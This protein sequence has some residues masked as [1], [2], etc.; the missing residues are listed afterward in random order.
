M[1]FKSLNEF[2]QLLEQKGELAKIDGA[3]GNLEMG[4]LT[5]L[6]W[7]AGGRALL[8]ENIK[9]YPNSYRVAT[10]LFATRKRCLLALD[11]PFDLTE[12]EA[13]KKF[14]E[15]L[16]GYKPIPP[17]RVA[18]GPIT[19]N[20]L[21]GDQVDLHKIPAPVWHELDGGKYI[22]TGCCVILKDPEG[23]WINVGTYRVMV[24]DS[25]TAGI[26]ISPQHQGTAI[27]KKYWQSGRSCPVAVALGP[28]PALF[29]ASSGGFGFDWGVSEY[30]VTGYLNGEPVEVILDEVTAL[31]IPAHSEAVLVG[32]IPPPEAETRP[33]GP[34]G[35][36]TGYYASGS[37]PEPVIRVKAIYHRN[38]PI[39][40]GS[41]PLRPR[42]PWGYSFALPIKKRG[43]KQ[44]LTARGIPD[45]LD[46]C[47]VSIPG[48]A[49]VKIKQRDAEHAAKIGAAAVRMT[50]ARM[51]VVVEEDIDIRDPQQVL[52]AIGTRC[53]PE[54]AIQIF[55]DCSTHSLD[56]GVPPEKRLKGEFTT[57]KLVINACRPHRWAADFPPVN[58]C[59][60]ALR[61][62][63]LEKWRRLFDGLEVKA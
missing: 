62:R 29:I 6:M 63:V 42:G 55:P 12:D 61:E 24:H 19:E 35:E 36:F 58:R 54:T 1:S 60:K 50:S 48:V 30:D 10:N 7:D 3:D 17:K 22:G 33:E 20:M 8:F 4:A 41:P 26:F 18:S 47:T 16:A 27:E 11:M 38:D 28:E 52:W 25:K 49:V 51:V 14:E 32:E 21:L 13:V 31:P 39:L 46:D 37:R 56:P 23:G 45:V 44:K 59:S 34:F 15:R 43:L 40:L 2:V 57:A 5:E 9:N 53:D